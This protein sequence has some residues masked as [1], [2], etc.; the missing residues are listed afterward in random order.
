M[1]VAS[2]CILLLAASPAQGTPR[3]VQTWIVSGWKAG[4]TIPLGRWQRP[5]VQTRVLLSGACV[6][7]VAPKSRFRILPGPG[8]GR[9]EL[10]RGPAT[11]WIGPGTSLQVAGSR[12]AGPRALRLD[13]KGR[14]CRAARGCG[15][16]PRFETPP[17]RRVHVAWK[18]GRIRA[19]TGRGTSQWGRDHT[20]TVTAAAGGSM[21]LDTSS[22][23]S[24]SGVEQQGTNTIQKPPAKTL[25]RVRIRFGGER[26]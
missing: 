2:L 16:A 21:C 18:V 25:L 10:T 13:S 14:P 1:Y 5:S 8:C 15:V 6:L 7:E 17:L 24:A 11:V 3:T 9:L 12:W 22:S 19:Q 4:S 23:A 20:G 26:R